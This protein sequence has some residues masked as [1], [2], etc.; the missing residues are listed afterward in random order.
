MHYAS[1]QIKKPLDKF[2][3]TAI[4]DL[5]LSGSDELRDW[6]IC[7]ITDGIRI[8]I[9]MIRGTRDRIYK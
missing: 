2:P 1:C 9:P 8:Y 6:T 5:V 4:H 7:Q 3:Q